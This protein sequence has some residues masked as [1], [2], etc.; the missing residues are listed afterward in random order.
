MGASIDH[1]AIWTLVR[2]QHGVISHA[3]LVAFRLS[4]KAIRH[5][6]RTGRLHSLQFPGVY[7]V[8]RRELTREGLWMAAVL[9]SGKGAALSHES[10]AQLL[11][12]RRYERGDIEVSI[13][14]ARTVRLEGIRAHRR[15]PMPETATIR[16][17]PVTQPLF[18]LV[19]LAWS[20][21]DQRL[22]AAINEADKLGLVD[23]ETASEA[24]DRLP[25]SRESQDCGGY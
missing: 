4:P 10:A 8:G 16:S 7:A 6:L 24:L 22:E 9:A 20:L 19:D 13:P 2:E 23:Q 15:N 17:I 18:T 11:G 12:I 14:A 1:Q 21:E 5:R 3:Q 25:P